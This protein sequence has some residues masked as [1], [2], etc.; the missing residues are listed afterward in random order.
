MNNRMKG[1][2]DK[3]VFMLKMVMMNDDKLMQLD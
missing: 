2:E 3:L 1:K